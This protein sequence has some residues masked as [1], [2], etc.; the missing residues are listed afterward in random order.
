MRRRLQPNGARLVTSASTRD[1]GTVKVWDVRTAEEQLTLESPRPGMAAVSLAYNRD[2]TAP[3]RSPE[4][5]QTSR[6]HRSCDLGYGVGRRLQTLRTHSSRTRFR[7]LAFSP[8]G[9]RIATATSN[10]PGFFAG[11]AGM[12]AGG[13]VKLWDTS[14]GN[15]LM[16]LKDLDRNSAHDLS[17]SADGTRLYAVGVN[18]PGREEK[19]EIRTW[20]ATPRGVK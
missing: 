5:G 10:S 16:T 8:D 12:A 9:R 6:G 3:G 7:R 14:T 1:S 13:E 18:V 15:E 17:F 4:H 19:I 11:P 20:D 2:G